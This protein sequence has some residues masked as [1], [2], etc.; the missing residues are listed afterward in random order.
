MANPRKAVVQL[1]TEQ[2]QYLQGF[3][4][5]GRPAARMVLRVRALLLSDMNHADGQR[6]DAY[7]V[8]ATG[9]K[10]RTL[11]R[12]RQQFVRAGLEATL[13]RKVRTTPPVPPKMTGRLEAQLITLACSPAPP[14]H[15]SWT[16]ALLASELTRLEYVQSIGR[17]TVRRTLKKIRSSP[18][19][20]SGFASPRRIGRASSLRWSRC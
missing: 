20:K 16:T 5:K 9:I 15:T 6:T 12:L 7:I 11:V 19:E 8:Q 4:R 17:E 13:Q 18:G 14:G 1:S 10:L 2:R 3:T